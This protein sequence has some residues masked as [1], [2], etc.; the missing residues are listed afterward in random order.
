MIQ[1]FKCVKEINTVNWYNPNTIASSV[2]LIG[3][4]G[5]IRGNK[6]RINRQFIRNFPQRDHFFTNRIV[7]FWNELPE[8]VINSKTVNSFK[9]RYDMYKSDG[10]P[11]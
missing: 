6:H 4:A 9:K 5:S 8:E 1:Y 2:G 10:C 11:K 7:P 3:P